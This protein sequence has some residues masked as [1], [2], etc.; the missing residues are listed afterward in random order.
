MGEG[1]LFW[2]RAFGR[3]GA[4]EGDAAGK[5]A[6]AEDEDAAGAQAEA[7][8]AGGNGLLV[9]LLAEDREEF[10]GHRA[11]GPDVDVAVADE[12]FGGGVGV[13]RL[14]DPGGRR[15]HLFP[16]GSAGQGCDGRQNQGC[17]QGCKSS[18][19]NGLS[20]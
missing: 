4:S 10:D 12:N 17:K 5:G 19:H 16:G 15:G 20:L 6:G 9:D 14:Y 2:G 11:L 18:D 3:P 8:E 7:M 1:E 13:E